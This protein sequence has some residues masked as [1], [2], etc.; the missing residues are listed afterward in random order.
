MKYA[1]VDIETTGGHA[2]QGAITEIAIIV[3]DGRHELERFHSLVNPEMPIPRYITALTGIS[4]ETVEGAPVF[5]EL[6]ES[7]FTLLSDCIFVAHNVNFDYSFLLHHLQSAGFALSAR[8]LC[9]VR[10]A[11]KVVPGLP[12]YSLGNLCRSLEIPLHNRHRATGDAQATVLLLEHLWRLD[13]DQKHLKSLL[14]GRQP[15]S[16]LPPN[17]QEDEVTQLPE[18]S[19]VYYFYDQKDQLLYV[20]KARNLRKRVKSHFSNNDGGR[21][22]QELLRKVHRI[23]YRLTSSELMALIV[24]SVEIRSKWPPYNRSQ[25]KFHPQYALYV[26]EDQ[27]GYQRMVV[28]KKRNH[29]PYWYSCNTQQ[30]GV[31]LIRMLIR[32]FDLDMSVHLVPQ[33]DYNT[34]RDTPAVN[35]QKTLEALQHLHQ[36]LPSFAVYDQDPEAETCTLLLMEQGAFQGWGTLNTRDRQ[37]DL[38]YLKAHINPLPDN[39]YIRALIYQYAQQYPERKISF[40]QDQAK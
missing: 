1:I 26:Y 32:Q 16:Y 34:C 27:R 30:E 40:N 7:I 33:I 37:P 15:G 35:N 10:Y 20:G 11:R 38:D 21:R 2:R 4:D 25:K 31:N 22:K 24:E 17:L 39:D 36:L 13:T 14:K 23:A 12:S 3:H 19:G 18:A 9:T 5:A 28:E 29:L 6:A 8:K